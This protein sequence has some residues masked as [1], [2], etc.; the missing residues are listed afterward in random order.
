VAGPGAGVGPPVAIR[1][2]VVTA[3][4]PVWLN[5]QRDAIEATDRQLLALLRQRA[6]QVREL[7]RCKHVSGHALCA[8]ERERELLRRWLLWSGAGEIPVAALTR[9]F[10]AVLEATRPS[11]DSLEARTPSELL[12]PLLAKGAGERP[13]STR[14]RTAAVAGDSTRGVCAASAAETRAD[15]RQRHGAE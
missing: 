10:D 14:L 15:R 5:E 6:R 1:A 9:V 7:W 11:A 12:P 8:P 3:D 13:E 2:A 4:D